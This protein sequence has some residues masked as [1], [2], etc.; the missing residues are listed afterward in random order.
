[1]CYTYLQYLRPPLPPLPSCEGPKLQPFSMDADDL[2]IDFIEPIFS[3]GHSELWK[4]AIK[5]QVYALK[6]VSPKSPRSCAF[7]SQRY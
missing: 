4:V 5:G 3:G 6:M 2:D 1:M 7:N